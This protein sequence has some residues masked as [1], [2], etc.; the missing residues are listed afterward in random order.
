MTTPAG[1]AGRGW[2][3]G[4]APLVFL[5]FLAIGAFLLLAEHRAHLPGIFGYLPWLLLLACPLLHVFMHGGHGGHGSH[6]GSGD[7]SAGSPGPEP[8]RH[9]VKGEPS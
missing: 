2:L 3:T 5:G 6:G 9:D 8:H 1:Q 4:R 7:G